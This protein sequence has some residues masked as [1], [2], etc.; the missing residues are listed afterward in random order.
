MMVIVLFILREMFDVYISGYV[1]I[2]TQKNMSLLKQGINIS[3]KMTRT[4]IQQKI[5][6]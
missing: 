5:I 2:H 1:E 6:L 3:F 4:F